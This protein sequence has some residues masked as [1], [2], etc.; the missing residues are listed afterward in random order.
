MRTQLAVRAENFQPQRFAKIALAATLGI[1]IS[2]ITA[3]PDTL[4]DDYK[5]VVIGT[6]TWMAENLNSNVEGSKCYGNDEANC[7]KYGRLYNWAAAMA[8]PSSCN[9]TSCASQIKAKHQGI[10]PN[11]WHI[12]SNADWTKLSNYIETQKSCTDCA[13]KYLK[14]TS[15]WNS[16]GNGTDIYGFS[17]VPGGYGNPDGSFVYIGDD[18]IWWSTSENSATNAY[19]L[20][21]GNNRE[22]THLKQN[23]KGYLF[24]A[25]CL[26]D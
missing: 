19:Y 20:S 12:P 24:F 8:L 21:V 6:Q 23:R 7:N 13:G 18:S 9:S 5:T 4:G 11:G 16:N 2:L 3:C 1:A 14:A 26:K 25:R 17:A 15:G 10:C 22:D